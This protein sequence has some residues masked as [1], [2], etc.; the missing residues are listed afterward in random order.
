MKILNGEVA[1]TMTKLAESGRSSW[2]TRSKY[3]LGESYAK[4]A[5]INTSSTKKAGETI[6]EPEGSRRVFKICSSGKDK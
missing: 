3:Y 5:K 2:F 4:L 6:E 1:S